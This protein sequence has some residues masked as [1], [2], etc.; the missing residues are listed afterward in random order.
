MSRSRSTVARVLLAAAACMLICA[1]LV[2]ELPEQLTLTND[3]SNDYVVGNPGALKH[4]GAFSSVKARLVTADSS[5]RP[6]AE[7]LFRVYAPEVNAI[8]ARSFS[9]QTVVPT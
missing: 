1:V 5:A 8:V 2:S 9:I 7:S 4:A 3:T 6:T